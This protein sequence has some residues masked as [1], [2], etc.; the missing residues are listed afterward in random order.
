[1]WLSSQQIETR[2]IE[3]TVVNTKKR[4]TIVAEEEAHFLQNWTIERRQRASGA[5]DKVI[6]ISDYCYALIF[7]ALYTTYINSDKF[8]NCCRVQQ[9]HK[10]TK[11]TK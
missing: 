10:P 2:S 4:R 9:K 11:V 7:Y 1:M 6:F 5:W 8:I 3:Q